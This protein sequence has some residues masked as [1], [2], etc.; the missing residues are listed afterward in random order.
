VRNC[1]T[2][3]LSKFHSSKEITAHDCF[4]S[5]TVKIQWGNFKN[6]LIILVITRSLATPYAGPHKLFKR[7][8]KL[9]HCIFTVAERK[10]SWAVISFEEWNLESSGKITPVN[11]IITFRLPNNLIIKNHIHRL[12]FRFKFWFLQWYF[13]FFFSHKTLFFIKHLKLIIWQSKSNNFIY[14][15]NFPWLSDSQ[16]FLIIWVSHLGKN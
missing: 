6:L 8:L 14:R 5:A 9:P 16:S 12:V 7:F 3:E 11:K 4:L 13:F 2:A 1:K 15:S 10:Q